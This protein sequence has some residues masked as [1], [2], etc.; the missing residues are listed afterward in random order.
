MVD[1]ERERRRKPKL[2]IELSA[3]E[4]GQVSEKL[5]EERA[6][7]LAELVEPRG[8]GVRGKLAEV[9]H[10]PVVTDDFGTSGSATNG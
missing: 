6:F 2:E 8:E 3:I 4:L 10:A 5:D 9:F 7:L 1:Q